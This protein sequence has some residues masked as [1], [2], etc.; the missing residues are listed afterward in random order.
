L[1][2]FFAAT[3]LLFKSLDLLVVETTSNNFVG[4]R[5]RG[6][7]LFRQWHPLQKG[8]IEPGICPAIPDRSYTTLVSQ[9]PLPHFGSLYQ[10]GVR[11]GIFPNGKSVWGHPTYD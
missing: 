6:E 7:K 5:W 1:G 4:M 8:K 10:A 3:Q 9:H 2:Y 11:R